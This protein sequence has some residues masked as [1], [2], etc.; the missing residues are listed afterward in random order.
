MQQDI[1]VTRAADAGLPEGGVLAGGAQAPAFS[2]SYRSYVLFCMMLVYVVNYLDRQILGI[3]NPQIRAEFH[4]TNWQI[5]L[6]N[7]PV[8]ALM[9]A[10]L[11]IPIAIIA[12][13]VNRRNVIAGSLALFSLMTFLSAYS[14]KF[15]QLMLA[16][17]GTGIGEAGTSPSVN[18]VLADLYPPEQR[19]SALAFYSAGLNIG[20]LFAFFGGG[21]IAEH[22]GWRVAFQAAGIPG[23]VLALLLLAT[24]R[25]P[26]RGLVENLP[27]TTPAP[28]IWRT[29]GFLLGQ[30]SFLWMSIGTGL[31]SFGGYAAIAFNP[32]FFQSAHHLSLHVIGLI[33]SLLAGVAGAVGTYL[34]GVFADLFA[35]KDVRWNMYILIWAT[36]IGLP[37]TPIFYL[38]PNLTI[39]VAA[40]IIPSMIGA[41]FVG[42]A[43]AMTQALVPLRMRARS[44]AILLFILNIIGLALA[45]PIVGK[46]ADLLEPAFGAQAI[47]Y[48]L[49][50]GMV[51]SLMGAF[52]YWRAA[53]TLKADIAR[54]AGA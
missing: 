47:R 9:Y 19:A 26:K 5:G 15:W 20:L 54:V 10:T 18:S 29:A 2:R 22:Y 41:C 21:W 27:D 25:E 32:Q 52:C 11:G 53:R 51:T 28:S 4:V 38:S 23:F 17:F 44:A 8:F 48:A 49:L 13:R 42:P 12:D 33:L 45:A 37:F 1:S 46:I 50:A 34:F 6:L 40:A 43:Y 14:A 3:L 36:F 30:P 24:V 16:R 35:K 39:A 7:G 31:S